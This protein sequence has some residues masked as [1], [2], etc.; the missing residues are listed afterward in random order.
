MKR[1]YK[2]VSQAMKTMVTYVKNF[3][4][5]DTGGGLDAWKATV[6]IRAYALLNVIYIALML[7]ACILTKHWIT[8][9]FMM[10]S[11]IASIIGLE[12]VDCS[13]KKGIPN[14]R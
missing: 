7:F 14:V 10:F 1:W 2:D 12:Y 3:M 4:I 6:Q 9:V 8:T 13:T 5:M 11:F